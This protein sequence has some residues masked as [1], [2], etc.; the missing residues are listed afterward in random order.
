MCLVFFTTCFVF[1]ESDEVGEKMR[2]ICSGKKD[3]KVFFMRM[4]NVEIV[5]CGGG[6]RMWFATERK[7]DGGDSV[8]F[9]PEWKWNKGE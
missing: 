4:C 1:F 6:E 7:Q 5:V 3:V 9:A 8:W 2:G